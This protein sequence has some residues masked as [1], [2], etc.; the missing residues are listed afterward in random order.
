MGFYQFESILNVLVNS[1]WFI[2]IP[3]LWVYGHYK[4]FTLSVQVSILDVRIN[5]GAVRVNVGPA[6]G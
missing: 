6:S 3:M 4:Y 2:W 5:P 1:F